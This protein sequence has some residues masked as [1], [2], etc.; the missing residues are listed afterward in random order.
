MSVKDKEL[1][2]LKE[3]EVIFCEDFETGEIFVK[4]GKC[5]P[6]TFEKMKKK[7]AK[8]GRLDFEVVNIEEVNEASETDK[9]EYQEFLKWKK[10][11]RK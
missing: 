4:R 5:P 11:G 2:E 10:R 8:R 7:I 3:C 6:G 1:K 9:T